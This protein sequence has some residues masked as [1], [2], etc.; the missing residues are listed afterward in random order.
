MTKWYAMTEYNDD[1]EPFLMFNSLDAVRKFLYKKRLIKINDN[2]YKAK[3]SSDRWW[4]ICNVQGLIETFGKGALETVNYYGYR[5]HEE[6]EK[7]Y[8]SL[9][10]TWHPWNTFDNRA[11]GA[12]RRLVEYA[13][14][15][16][17]SIK[18]ENPSSLIQNNYWGK[19]YD[20]LHSVFT[21]KNAKSLE[22]LP[23]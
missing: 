19:M 22:E 11:S 23:Q 5:D 20:R 12:D 8:W 13:N 1:N 9:T 6:F 16:K 10:Y 3:A 21:P 14:K 18:C 7:H 4:Y 17:D 15:H 2:K